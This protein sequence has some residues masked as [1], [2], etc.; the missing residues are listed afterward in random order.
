MCF[1]ASMDSAKDTAQPF[2]SQFG[3]YGKDIL[4]TTHSQI[5]IRIFTS[6]EYI[7]KKK[8]K[9]NSELQERSVTS[10]L[11]IDANMLTILQ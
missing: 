7:A 9:I 10:W 4:A 2:G 5:L 11:F 1:S 8:K 6:G 3:L